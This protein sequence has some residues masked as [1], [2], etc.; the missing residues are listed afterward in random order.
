MGTKFKAELS[1]EEMLRGIRSFDYSIFSEMYKLFFKGLALISVKYVQDVYVAEELVQDVFLKIWEKPTMLDGVVHLKA[2]LYRA[3]VNASINYHN[4]QK[5]LRVHQEA[6]LLNVQEQNMERDFEE[7][8]FKILIYQEIDRLPAQCKKVFKM[9]RFDE[10]KYREIAM[11]LGISE[12]TV[13]NHIANAVKILRDRFLA[14]EE[15]SNQGYW[16]V[17]S[18]KVVLE[19]ALF[20]FIVPEL[21]S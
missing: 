17:K 16:S 9:S 19:L 10:L 13:E 4:R 1:N 18:G 14:N 2:Y 20:V 8:E 21:Y 15:L 3:V 7:N 11:M 5:K 12:K 6:M